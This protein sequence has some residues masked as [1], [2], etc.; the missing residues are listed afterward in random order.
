MT[1]TIL[2]PRLNDFQRKLYADLAK[3]NPAFSFCEGTT[4]GLRSEWLTCITDTY[5]E[6]VAKNEAQ[7]QKHDQKRKPF[8]PASP[9]EIYRQTHAKKRAKKAGKRKQTK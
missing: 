8:T 2:N 7:E 9:S 1:R 6:A 4:M 3:C 5:E